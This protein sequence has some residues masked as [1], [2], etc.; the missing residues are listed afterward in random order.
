MKQEIPN[1]PR[2][3][4]ALLIGDEL[5]TGKRT[6]KHLSKLIEM[7][8][9]RGLELSWALT[10][11]DDAT[12]L[13]NA[14]KLSLASADIVFSFGGIGATPDDRTRQCVAAA[15]GAPLEFNVEGRAVLEEIMGERVYPQR[16]HMIEW[17]VG[18]KMIP[19]PVNRV[20]G[21]SFREHHFVPGFPRMAWPMVAWVLDTYYID[22]HRAEPIQEYVF[23][24]LN[25]PESDLIDEMNAVIQAHPDVRLSCLPN[26]DGRRVIEFGL[27][28]APVEA[29]AAYRQL[30]VTLQQRDVAI[31]QLRPPAQ[32]PA[33]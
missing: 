1:M 26:A 27:R 15:A 4:G 23:E 28:G 21:F 14:L 5:L 20:P 2:A 13:T 8:H 17:P 18:A 9:A 11:G 7:L 24:A 32:Q 19:N 6:D 29:A 10:V 12:R 30:I 33:L 22:L 25:T 31:N 3:F 16:I